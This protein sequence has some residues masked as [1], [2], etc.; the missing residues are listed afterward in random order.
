MVH[1]A[2]SLGGRTPEDASQDGSM[3]KK[4]R[5]LVD[6]L[7]DCS[8]VSPTAIS[9][10]C[11]N[12]GLNSAPP[13]GREAPSGEVDIAALDMAG[14]A[15]L[16]AD[17]L[18][19]TQLDLAFRASQKGGNPELASQFARALIG[20]T[21]KEAAAGHLPA[22]AHLISQALAKGNPAEALE[23]I[24]AGEKSDCENNEGRR[25]NDFELRRGQVLAKLGEAEQARGVFG[26]LMD[27]VPAELRYY[28]SATEAMLGAKQGK[29]AL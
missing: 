4:L 2:P 14:L 28:D 24:D 15:G 16:S 8:R 17:K 3:R 10:V 18:N 1:S 23:L 21:G 7:E 29:T 12:N 19:A 27:R 13:P 5:G 20:H 11:R 22:F 26:Q 9:I 6:F 25:R